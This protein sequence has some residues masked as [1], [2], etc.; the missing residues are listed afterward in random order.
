MWRNY[1]QEAWKEMKSA[2]SPF[3]S[4]EALTV[5]E[6]VLARIAPDIYGGM[7]KLDVKTF[8]KELRPVYEKAKG[9]NVNFYSFEHFL[10]LLYILGIF[11]TKRRDE[12][13]QDIFYSY[14]RGNRNYHSNGEVRIHPTVL[15]AFG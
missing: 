10:H 13:D 2:A 6:H 1:A 4:P 7:L 9:N 15:K 12:Y 14:H 8:A 11:L 5:L 3:L